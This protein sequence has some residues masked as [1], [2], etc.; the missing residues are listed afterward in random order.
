MA[1]I[2]AG[3]NEAAGALFYHGGALDA[4]RRA[5]A[6]APEPWIDLST[7]ICPVAYPVGDIPVESWT[8]LPD[9]SDLAALEAEAA[10]AYGVPDPACVV[11]AAGSQTLLQVLPR[12][13]PGRRVAILGFTYA[14]HA[15]CWARS[16]A[17]VRVV[18]A[19]D[20]LAAADV[21]VVVN[22]NNPDG[23]LVAPEELAALARRMAGQG[24]VLV[25]DEAFMDVLPADRAVASRVGDGAGLLVL[26]SFGKTYGLAG[27]RLGF[28]L[29]D[30]RVTAALRETL[31]PWSVSGPALAVGRRALADAA[32]LAGLKRRLVDDSARLQ[33]LME[34]LGLR[35]VGGT[36]LFRLGEHAQARAIFDRLGRRGVLVRAFAERPGWLRF[37]LPGGAQWDL[38]GERLRGL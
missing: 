38:L 34:G 10:R 6:R 7:G 33:E 37:G 17:E 36:P 23:R 27:L 35:A 32:W 16:G 18:E 11:A 30:R 1:D 25:V 19:P 14:E 21:G 26:R 12:L 28:A 20:E 2:E 4:A 15:L 9:A 29:G 5:F 3:Q 8:R 24:G 22:P 31:G 13:F